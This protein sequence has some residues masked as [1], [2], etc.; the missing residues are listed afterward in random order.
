M[1]NAEELYPEYRKKL[2]ANYVPP[3]KCTRYCCG[4]RPGTETGDNA[5]R[6]LH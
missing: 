2:E 5:G 4:W 3:E 6:Y 1:G